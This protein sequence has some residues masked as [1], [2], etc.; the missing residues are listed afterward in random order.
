MSYEGEFRTNLV[1][2]QDV[3]YKKWTFGMTKFLSAK[4]TDFVIDYT[5]QKPELVI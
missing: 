4:E 3:S 2:Y 5:L 1:V